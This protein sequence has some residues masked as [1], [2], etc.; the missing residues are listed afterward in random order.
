MN[1]EDR[2]IF[3]IEK[4]ASPVSTL[5]SSNHDQTSVKQARKKLSVDGVTTQKQTWRDFLAHI[6]RDDK[7]K[8]QIIDALHISPITLTRWITGKSEPRLHNLRQMLGALPPQYQEQMSHYLREE[9]KAGTTLIGEESHLALI[10]PSEFYQQV[11]IARATTGENLRFWSLSQLIIQQALGQLDP[12][13]RGMS[14]W[15]VRCMPPS[16]PQHKVRSLRESV[17][18]GTSPWKSNL[19]QDAMFLGAES[20]VGS[21]VTSYRPAIVQDL[22]EEHNLLALSRVEHEKSIVIYPILYCGRIAGV[23]MVSSAE[24]NFFL[25]AARVELIHS[26]ADLAALAFDRDQFYEPEQIMLEIMPGYV[27]QKSYFTHFRQLMTET[28]LDAVYSN[29][30][31]DNA[32]ADLFVWQKLEEQLA[33]KKIENLE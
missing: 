13:R 16:G 31:I 1:K 32:Q 5:S 27:E 25:H 29:R 10:I 11:F 28:I 19:E 3:N 22:D 17:G 12:E 8:Q 7:V 9:N 15:I 6:I 18:A 23:F 24:A 33:G 21:V 30:R 4:N 20:L 26:Y 14:I 2:T